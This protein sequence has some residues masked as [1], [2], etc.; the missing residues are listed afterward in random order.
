MQQQQWQQQWQRLGS[1]VRQPLSDILLQLDW[2]AAQ[3]IKRCRL[4]GKV[5]SCFWRFS[6]FLND[7]G[8]IPCNLRILFRWLL[9]IAGGERDAV[10]SSAR[11]I[12]VFYSRPAFHPLPLLLPPLPPCLHFSSG[13][14]RQ[15]WSQQDFSSTS[16]FSPTVLWSCSSAPHLTRRL[17]RQNKGINYELCSHQETQSAPKQKTVTSDDSQLWVCSLC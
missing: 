8:R 15:G 14:I 16:I 1:G 7:W 17:P 9:W 13:P 12:E 3:L 11:M 5:L 10:L 2:E 4:G 6:S